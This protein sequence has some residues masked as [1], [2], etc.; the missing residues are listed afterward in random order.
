MSGAVTG[1][2]APARRPRAAVRLLALAALATSALAAACGGEQAPLE[3]PEPLFDDVPVQYPLELWDRGVEGQTLLRVRITE[4][5]T[6]DS[7][8]VRRSSGHAAFDSAAMRGARSLRFEPARR[9][10][11]AVRVWAQVPV[12]FSREPVRGG[13]GGG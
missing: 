11:D 13:A 10:E 6:V 8:E 9:G 3:R 2:P 5:G 1:E 12:R 7:V 4:E